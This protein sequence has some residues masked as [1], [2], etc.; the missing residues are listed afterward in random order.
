[1]NRR[2]R[3]LPVAAAGLL[4][5]LLAFVAIAPGSNQALAQGEQKTLTTP[6][7]PFTSIQINGGGSATLTFGPE[8]SVTIEGNSLVVDRLDAK[9]ENGELIL[10]SM[11]TVATA[12]VSD[13]TY[14][15]VTPSISA[16]HLAGTISLDVPSLPAQDSLELGLTTGADVTIDGMQVGSVTGKL[17][18][19]S[20][21]HLSGSADTM[22]LEVNNGSTLDAAGLQ[23]GSADLVLNGMAEA[24][25]RV[26]DSLTGRA[27]QG[28]TVSYISQT[29]EPDMELTTMASVEHLPFTEWTAPVEMG[30][31]VA[32]PVA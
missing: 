23:V 22:Q 5:G 10:G 13:L 30:S 15:I 24:T 6:M 21:A 25:V 18:L 7:E 3:A 17:D 1:M 20:N 28:S 19:L 4:I 32:S 9:V 29:V 2:F 8:S 16:I 26:T 12:E 14:T 31:P 27:A 11:L